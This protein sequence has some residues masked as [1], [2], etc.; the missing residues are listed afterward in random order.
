MN[1][2]HQHGR[3]REA[4]LPRRARYLTPDDYVA[5]VIAGDRG[6]LARAITLVESSSHPHEVQ[7]QEVLQRLLPRTG[8]ARR[9]GIT[10]VPG[11]GKSTFI[12]SFGCFLVER[13]HRLAVLTIDPTSSRTGG[14]ILGDKT[15]MEQLSRH[16]NAYIRPTPTG[17][18]LG[19]VARRTR[20]TMLLCEAAG[21]DIVI[22]ETVGVGQ[23]EIAIRSMVDFFLLLLL[24]GAGDELQGIKKGIME[25]ADAVLVNKADGD[26]L[27]KARQAL[28]EHEAAL[29]Y[30]QPATPKWK[31]SAALASGLT[32][33]GIPELWETIERFYRE[34][35]PTGVITRRRQQQLLEWFSDLIGDELQRQFYQDP[36]VKSRLPVLQEEV[37]RGVITAVRAARELLELTKPPDD[38]PKP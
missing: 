32:G 13:G 19:G 2:T 8:K 17:G 5:G 12:E 4:V 9:I 10:G 18:N 1:E 15:R 3:N 14:S 6:V 20:E 26:N 28:A 21:F 37:L 24:P 16:P 11:V 22:L 33:Q 30:A 7:A 23:S 34:L 25:I 36:R 35:E 29:H 31:T 27:L 38:L